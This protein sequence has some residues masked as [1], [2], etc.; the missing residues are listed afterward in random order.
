MVQLYNKIPYFKKI[1]NPTSN[2]T[3][4]ITPNGP[5][6]PKLVDGKGGT[7]KPKKEKP[8]NA[9]DFAE[10]LAKTIMMVKNTP[11]Y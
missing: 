8:N 5:K 9:K 6:D 7:K 1:N 2:T 10:L 11:A 4:P 3:A